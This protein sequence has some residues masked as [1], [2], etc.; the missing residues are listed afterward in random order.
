MDTDRPR[1][2]S[3]G[4]AVRVPTSVVSAVWRPVVPRPPA[5]A[6]PPVPGSLV[7]TAEGAG[8][9]MTLWGKTECMKWGKAWVASGG[10]T[11]RTADSVTRMPP[12]ISLA[13]VEI[14][15]A[16]IRIFP[17]RAFRPKYRPAIRARNDWTMMAMMA[18][19]AVK[20]WL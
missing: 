4:V 1:R 20:Y 12:A 10:P 16:L 2:G 13:P 3:P 9:G 18:W 11:R 5:E 7:V 8:E 17:S 14:R 6:Y 19:S 15:S